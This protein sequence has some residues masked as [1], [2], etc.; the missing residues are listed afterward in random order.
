MFTKKIIF[1]EKRDRKAV[2]LEIA[3]QKAAANLVFTPKIHSAVF[4]ETDCTITMG[5]IDS[6]CLADMHGD[7][8]K[9][10]PNHFWLKIQTI[11]STLYE[12]GIIYV[13]ITPYNFIEH[14]G[15]LYIIDFGDAY[16]KGTK[17]RNW[18][19]TEFLDLPYGWN[20]DFA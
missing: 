17:P 9:D 13:D 3:L 19:H 6:L 11:I 5:K 7:K 16:Y 2:E 14:N 1:T 12:A 8:D 18:F 20:P 10:L 15:T 4:T